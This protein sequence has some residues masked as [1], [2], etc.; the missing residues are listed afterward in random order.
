MI[1]DAANLASRI[2]GLTKQY[3]V[4]SLVGNE[5]AKALGEFAILEADLIQVVGRKTPERIFIL[6]GETQDAQTPEY[7]TLVEKQSVFLST[8]REQN[9]DRATALIPE[10]KKLA[11]PLGCDGY[12]DVMT[13]RITA[14]LQSPPPADWGGV[15][16][17]TSK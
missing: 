10:L 1:G 13:D 2:E 5:T 6:A 17:A 3:K 7:K 9:W 8:Y 11:R 15:Y 12:Y 4:S 16:V 14:Y